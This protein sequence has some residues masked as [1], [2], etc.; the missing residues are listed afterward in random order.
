MPHSRQNESKSGEQYEKRRNESRRQSQHTQRGH[1][2]V[3]TPP[4][5]MSS[6]SWHEHEHK[7]R[8]LRLQIDDGP[9]SE[10]EY[11]YTKFTIHERRCGALKGRYSDEKG[12]RNEHRNS[13]EREYEQRRNKV[14]RTSGDVCQ[15]AR[16]AVSHRMTC[17]LSS[18]NTFL[19]TVQYHM[20]RGGIVH[21]RHADDSPQP[22]EDR[23]IR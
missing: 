3:P 18:N 13:G 9:V 23:G 5:P 12:V 20:W 15:G 16:S 4:I 10:Y 2:A 11:K 22:S 19:S 8:S 17:R 1:E 21:V 7:C 14:K 6:A